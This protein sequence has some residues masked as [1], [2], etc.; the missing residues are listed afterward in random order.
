VEANWNDLRGHQNIVQK[1]Y[2]RTAKP[3]LISGK[4]NLLTEAEFEGLRIVIHDVFREK[5][6]MVYAK[7]IDF[8]ADEFGNFL[9]PG[10]PHH[11]LRR[12]PW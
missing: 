11:L 4:P 2:V 6:G 12:L 1:S 3:V 8:I 9:L 5:K 7:I 10:T